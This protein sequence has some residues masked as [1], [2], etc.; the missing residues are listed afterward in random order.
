M[1]AQWSAPTTVSR[2]SCSCQH[3]PQRSQDFSLSASAVDEASLA[4]SERGLQDVKNFQR[5]GQAGERRLE[6]AVSDL[7]GKQ[8]E[9]NEDGV[10]DVGHGAELSAIGGAFDG[11]VHEVKR[12][13]DDHER[14]EPFASVVEVVAEAFVLVDLIG[15]EQRADKVKQGGIDGEEEVEREGPLRDAFE[16]KLPPPEVDEIKEKEQRPDEVN[17]V[18]WEL[19]GVLDD[20][21]HAAEQLSDGESKDHAEQDFDVKVDVQL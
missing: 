14:E 18:D 16:R 10:A 11:C 17:P 9:N 15:K 6:E 20:A 7:H 5:N 19:L 8:T 3:R 4:E 13:D 2:M 1:L 12:K 21:R